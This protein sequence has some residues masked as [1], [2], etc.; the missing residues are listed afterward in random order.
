M[1]KRQPLRSLNRFSRL[2]L[3][4]LAYKR[5]SNATFKLVKYNIFCYNIIPIATIVLLDSFDEF[6]I[7]L[8]S[9]EFKITCL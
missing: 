5:R 9:N 1:K 6:S 8:K 2:D 4:E 3:K 7:I